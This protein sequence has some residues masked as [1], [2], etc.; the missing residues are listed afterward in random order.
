MTELAASAGWQQGV[1]VV[2]VVVVVVAAATVT[3]AEVSP[4]PQAHG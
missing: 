2:V 4:L 3:M 1:V